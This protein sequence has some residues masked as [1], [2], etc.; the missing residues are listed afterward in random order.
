MKELL[1]GQRISGEEK[2]RKMK[3]TR[4]VMSVWMEGE[5]DSIV[6]TKKNISVRVSEKK[7][8]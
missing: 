2:R 1:D 4:G 3:N 6:N 7:E 5:S 8:K